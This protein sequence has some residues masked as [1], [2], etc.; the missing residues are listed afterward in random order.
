[1]S[2]CSDNHEPMR[3]NWDE[4]EA[5]SERRYQWDFGDEVLEMGRCKDCHSDIAFAGEAE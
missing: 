4:F 5:R 2:F 1:M 3:T